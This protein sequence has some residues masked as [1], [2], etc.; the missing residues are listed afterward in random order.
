MKDIIFGIEYSYFNWEA[1]AT[2]N[3][4]DFY[5][6][7]GPTKSSRKGHSFGIKYK[8]N[9]IYDNPEV[10]DYLVYANYYGDLERLPDYQN[11]AASYDK[12]FN[13]GSSFNYKDMRASLGAVDNEKGFKLQVNLNNNFVRKTIYPQLHTNFDFGFALPINHSSI[14][15]RSSAGYSRGEREDPFANF[16]FGGF[17]NNYVDNQNEKRYREYY[18]FPGAELNSIGGTNFG[19]LVLD[20]N[21]PPVRFGNLGISSFYL[22]YAR[23][24]LFSSA[25]MTNIDLKESRRTLANTG[26]QVDFRFILFYHLKMTFSAG[27][28]AAFEKDQKF[29]DELMFS[30]KVF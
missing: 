11:V 23:V 7:F 12:L 3:N 1:Q 15:L 24:S 28:A 26:A 29:T 27:Y 30:L 19:K 18:S 10:M 16:F 22:N 2:L 5:D 21:L 14:W 8:Q 20:W 4:A 25:I 6:L 9:I 13:I 17:G